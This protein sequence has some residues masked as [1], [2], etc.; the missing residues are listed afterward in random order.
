MAQ[1]SQ[2]LARL[3]RDPVSDLPIA[4]R[5]EQLCDEHNVVFRG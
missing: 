4:D 3:K 2:I 5:V 1:V